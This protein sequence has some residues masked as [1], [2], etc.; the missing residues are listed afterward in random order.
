MDPQRNKPHRT[1][2]RNA[3]GGSPTTISPRADFSA[4]CWRERTRVTHAR[5]RQTSR[6]SYIPC[7]LATMRCPYQKRGL[8]TSGASSVT[9]LCVAMCVEL[10]RRSRASRDNHRAGR[11]QHRWPGPARPDDAT[12]AAVGDAEGRGRGGGVKGGKIRSRDGEATMLRREVSGGDETAFEYVGGKVC[13]S[14]PVQSVMT[15]RGRWKAENA[16]APIRLGDRREDRR[17]KPPRAVSLGSMASQPR[18]VRRGNPIASL[19][20]RTKLRGGHN[21][22][23]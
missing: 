23:P 3:R 2:K 14:S 19:P 21:V 6:C 11:E 9:A 15:G 16:P 10:R 20:S 12:R 5:H 4:G 22:R 8:L 13:F 1:E 7:F 17:W 18:Q